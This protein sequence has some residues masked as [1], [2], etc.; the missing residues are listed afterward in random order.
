MD[1]RAASVAVVGDDTPIAFGDVEQNGHMQFLYRHPDCPP[2]IATLLYHA[3]EVEARARGIDLL[4]AEVSE[5]AKRFFEKQGF[6]V[7][8]R[9]DFSIGSVPIH[10]YAMQKT[11]V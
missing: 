10:N 1:G 8:K 5:A 7:L 9:R 2:N 4:F 11:L 6:T 3:L